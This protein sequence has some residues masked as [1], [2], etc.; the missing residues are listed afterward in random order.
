MMLT[1]RVLI[2]MM[3]S[4]FLKE[5]KMVVFWLQVSIFVKPSLLMVV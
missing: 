3:K 2:I 1:M 4:V 5:E